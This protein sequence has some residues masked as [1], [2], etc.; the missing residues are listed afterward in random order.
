MVELVTFIRTKSIK[1]RLMELTARKAMFQHLFGMMEG[2]T[3]D[4]ANDRA[5]CMQC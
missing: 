4:P 5:A 1:M 2:H 3:D